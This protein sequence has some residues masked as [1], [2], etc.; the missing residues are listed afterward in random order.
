MK[1][2]EVGDTIVYM[3]DSK[4]EVKTII[5]KNHGLKNNHE[6][7][8]NINGYYYYYNDIKEVI[9]GIDREKFDPFEVEKEVNMWKDYQNNLE[10]VYG[11]TKEVKDVIETVDKIISNLY[12]LDQKLE[13]LNPEGRYIEVRGKGHY[14]SMNQWNDLLIFMGKSGLNEES[15]EVEIYKET[16][17]NK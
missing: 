12:Q 4:I 1:D 10:L 6:E 15:E 9:K 16:L 7:C 17:I 3:D 14:I 5:H 8:C 11:N 13:Y 2:I